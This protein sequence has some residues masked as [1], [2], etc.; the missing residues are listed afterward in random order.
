MF[1]DV[2]RYEQHGFNE[3]VGT[4]AADSADEAN[5]EA[6]RQWPMDVRLRQFIIPVVTFAEMNERYAPT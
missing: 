3:W 6:L 5:R 2:F 4:V 1:W